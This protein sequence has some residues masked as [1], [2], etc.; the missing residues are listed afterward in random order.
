MADDKQI[1]RRR[2]P[3]HCAVVADYRL[4]NAGEPIKACQVKDIS[5]VG[6]CIIIYENIDPGMRI[7]IK[8]YLPGNPF[9]IIAKGGVVWVKE[10][11]IESESRRR[12]NAG[13]EFIDVDKMDRQKIEHY[14]AAN[15]KY[16]DDSY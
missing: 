5:A 6:I 9:P 8:V 12:F 7:E 10:Y 4:I 1:E 13:I 11:K 3:R 2:F 15:S 16:K 14:I